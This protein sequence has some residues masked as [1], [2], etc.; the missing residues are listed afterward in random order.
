MRGSGDQGAVMN[1]ET[2]GIRDVISDEQGLSLIEMVVTIFIIA[3]T[4]T[5]LLSG[6]VTSFRAIGGNEA[7]VAATALGNELLETMHS[8][9]WD[10]LAM[11]ISEAPATFEGEN[12]VLVPDVEDAQ[13]ASQTIPRGG[14]QYEVQRWVTWS[15]DGD[16]EVKRMTVL[17]TWQAGNS[18]RSMRAAALRAPDPREVID[19]RVEFTELAKAGPS[20]TTE[21]GLNTTSEN[22]DSIVAVIEVTDPSAVVEIRWTGPDNVP[23]SRIPAPSNG[24]ERSVLIPITTG[25]FPNGPMAFVV[26]ASSGTG[27]EAQSASNTKSLNFFYELAVRPLTLTHADAPPLFC[28]PVGGSVSE[29][30]VVAPVTG[31]VGTDAVTGS[32]VLDWRV[33]GFLQEPI[34]MDFHERTDLGADFEAILPDSF[35][36]GVQLEFM[37]TAT[38]RLPTEPFHGI[39]TAAADITVREPIGDDPPC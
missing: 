4:F 29:V 12:V 21:I 28:V 37:V 5:A 16:R 30:K 23:R 20:G 18:E 9:P 26:L 38:R 7:Q 3:I 14:R 31:M 11:R 13:V 36:G 32:V 2:D 6:L 15:S 8:D 27:V 24:H 39:E 10:E 19:L 17:L 22:E 34:P 25:N 33:N 1:T 35:A